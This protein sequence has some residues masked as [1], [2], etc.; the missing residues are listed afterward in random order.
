MEICFL[1]QSQL[2]HHSRRHDLFH[3]MGPQIGLDVLQIQRTHFAR[4]LEQHWRAIR[5]VDFPA[6]SGPHPAPHPRQGRGEVLGLGLGLESELARQAR[7]RARRDLRGSSLVCCP[8]FANRHTCMLQ[9]ARP[10]NKQARVL[11][12]ADPM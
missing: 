6:L 10:L 11:M 3:P 4:A 12:H 8:S 7:L 9:L 5:R 1:R 2:T